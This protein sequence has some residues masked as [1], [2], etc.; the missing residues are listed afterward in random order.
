MIAAKRKLFAKHGCVNREDMS[1][2][3]EGLVTRPLQNFFL[4]AT[5]GSAATFP[6]HRRHVYSKE[7]HQG[8]CG[9]LW[10]CCRACRRPP[11][12]ARDRN[13]RNGEPKGEHRG[14]DP[15]NVLEKTSE[16]SLRPD[17]RPVACQEE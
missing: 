11:H 6:I 15:S 13:V 9:V 4:Q 2:R 1:P 16:S 3:E 10:T 14:I 8:V 5:K 7:S 17:D 12:A